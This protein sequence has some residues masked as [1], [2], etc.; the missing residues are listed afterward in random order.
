MKKQI[1]LGIILLVITLPFTSCK[2]APV[3]EFSIFGTWQVLT[4]IDSEAILDR[5]TFVDSVEELSGD[6]FGYFLA[7]TGSFSI[8]GNKITFTITVN[9]ETDGIIEKIFNGTIDR[10]KGSMS[11]TSTF[12]YIDHGNQTSTGNWTANKQYP[13]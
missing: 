3:E 6:V 5:I 2:K 8:N 13:D 12:K 9:N 4:T 7:E 10:D 1:Y 11:G